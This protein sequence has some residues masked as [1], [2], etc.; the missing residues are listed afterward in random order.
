MKLFEIRKEYTLKSLDINDVS[1]D[2]LR[3]FKSWFEEAVDAEALE[4]N[5]MCLST[6]GKDGFPNGRIV[7]LK[8]LDSG[9]VFFTNYESDK[10][11]ELDANPKASLTF[12]WPEIERQIRIQGEVSKISEAESDEYFFSRPY[13]S[14]IGAWI[15]AQSREISG[16]QELE[17]RQ[18]ETENRF[19][20][21]PME[22]PGHWGGYRLQ[23]RRIEFWQGRPSRL[24]DRICYEIQ[25][26]GEWRISRLSP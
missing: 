1:T 12:F 14:Q 13:G 8:E 23:A 3:Q 15:S 26:S 16:R 6:L 2:P 19:Q 17:E 24:H 25:D 9:F 7:L 22:R 4:V 18:K 20:K 10:G 5:A 21:V 11:K